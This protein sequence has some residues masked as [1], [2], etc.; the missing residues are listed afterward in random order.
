MN[1]KQ[2]ILEKLKEQVINR[3][4]NNDTLI[5]RVAEEV[6]DEIDYGDIASLLNVSTNDIAGEI[7]SFELLNEIAD[8]IDMDFLKEAIVERCD[9]DDLASKVAS[10]LPTNFLDDIAIQATEEIIAEINDGSSAA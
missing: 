4:A 2:M 10:M 5:R 6:L 3:M 9:M 7:D 8:T 1:C